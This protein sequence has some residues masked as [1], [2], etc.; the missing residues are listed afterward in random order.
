MAPNCPQIYPNFLNWFII[1]SDGACPLLGLLFCHSPPSPSP[2]PPHGTSLTFQK[3][4]CL[5]SLPGLCTCVPPS[6]PPQSEVTSR[7]SLP[8]G[9][10]PS[11]FQVSAVIFRT[12]ASLLV[13][14]LILFCLIPYFLPLTLTIGPRCGSFTPVTCCAL[15]RCTAHTG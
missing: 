13:A 10:W 12:Y 5:V 8:L 11:A 9:N 2:A 6:P 4:S 3:K 7:I 14:F 15:E 1:L